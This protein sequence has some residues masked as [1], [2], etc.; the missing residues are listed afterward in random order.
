[1]SATLTATN[2]LQLLHNALVERGLEMSFSF[3]FDFLS[4]SLSLSLSVCLPVPSLFSLSFLRFFL[5]YRRC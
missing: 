1:V 5:N 3:L 2:F 4:L